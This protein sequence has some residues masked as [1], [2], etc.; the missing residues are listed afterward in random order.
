MQDTWMKNIGLRW[1]EEW[2]HAHA[3]EMFD[4]IF[5]MKFMPPGR[6]LWAM[7]TD[8]TRKR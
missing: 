2:A 7:G 8:L 4:K 6:G 1:D 5:H 3:E